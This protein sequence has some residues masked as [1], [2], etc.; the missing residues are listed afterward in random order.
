MTPWPHG[1]APSPSA[2]SP[3][4]HTASPPPATSP[5]TS[6]TPPPR[7][8][9]RA[10]VFNKHQQIG[11]IGYV[12][13]DKA[14]GI[15]Y[16]DEFSATVTYDQT[17]GYPLEYIGQ[18]TYDGQAPQ[19]TER[20]VYSD[21]YDVYEAGVNDI[22]IDQNAPVEYYNLQGVRVETPAPGFYIRRQGNTAT[23]VLVR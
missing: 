12:D 17:H 14:N 1:A 5:T 11:E 21:Y 10:G 15:S 6:S 4:R 19:Y 16:Q 9:Y 3:P 7:Q 23:K 20:I 18:H 2:T 8:L 13:G 22:V